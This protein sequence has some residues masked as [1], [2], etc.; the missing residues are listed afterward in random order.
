MRKNSYFK[1][2]FQK[3]TELRRN[4][5]HSS[6]IRF[7]EQSVDIERISVVPL[8]IIVRRAHE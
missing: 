6:L 8:F 7:R 1:N 5:H 3:Q 4:I 2:S